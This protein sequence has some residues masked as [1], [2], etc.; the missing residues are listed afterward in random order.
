MLCNF[1]MLC[2][3]FAED[4][5]WIANKLFQLGDFFKRILKVIILPVKI[6]CQSV[7]PRLV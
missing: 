6:V 5:T 2:I 1:A 4:M 7:K 3:T